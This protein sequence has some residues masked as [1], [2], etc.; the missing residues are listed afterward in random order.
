MI[1]TRS[2]NKS[3]KRLYGIR[4]LAGFAFVLVIFLLS[5]GVISVSALT[6][7]QKDAIKSGARYYNTEEDVFIQCSSPTSP[8][9]QSGSVYMV[10]DSIG[11]QVESSL[12]SEFSNSDREFNANVVAGRTLPQGISAI[13]QDAD[14]IR[15]AGAVIVQLGTNAGGFSAANVQEMVNRIRALSSEATIFWVDTAVVER[16]DLALTL[17]N[18][19]RII[20]EQASG[21]SYRII[22]WNKE[23]FGSSAN[24]ADINPDAP[25]NGYLRRADQYVHL[26][27]DGVS[28]MTDLI[29]GS[30]AGGGSGGET[31]C[32]CSPG[33][34]GGNLTGSDAEEQTW[35]YFISKGLNAVQVAGI[36]G[37]FSQE[38]SFNPRQ[39]QG[40]GE[41]NSVPLDGVTGY[42]IAQWTY[43]TRQQNLDRFARDQNRPVATL[44]LQLDFTYK[45]MTEG[46]VWDNLRTIQDPAV[47]ARYFHSSFERSADDEAGIQERVNDALEYLAL[48]GSGG[49]GGGTT[50]PLDCDNSAPV[51]PD[52]YSYPVGP[53]RQSGGARPADGSHADDPVAW[54]FM[55]TGGT[56]VYAVYDG[57]ITAPSNNPS[58]P[59]YYHDVPGCYRINLDADDGYKYWYGHLQNPAV[60][61][62]QRVSAGQKIA[63]VARAEFGSACI[64]GGS[65]LHLDRGY[66]AGTQGG[67]SPYSRNDPNFIGLMQ[68]LYDELPE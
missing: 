61:D 67:G 4:K 15:S 17:S 51:N 38:D 7:A 56:P 44:E 47:A 2:L 5:Q 40:G 59:D 48:Y 60:V 41:S 28:A 58:S 49:G 20:Q 8:T 22:S 24:P 14:V 10:G 52:G 1:T 19:N 32:A 64:G 21:S 39:L 31:N 55:R 16:D 46:E 13:N 18:V 29:A 54:D 66:P 43:I 27:S 36:M 6:Q 63:E 57:V 65:H 33:G 68:R 62:G 23:V 45:E 26:T 35:N 53:L 34:G 3:L 12:D 11:T 50:G 37:N 9:S 42:G 30:V 25:D